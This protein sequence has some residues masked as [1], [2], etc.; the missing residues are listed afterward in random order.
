MASSPRRTAVKRLPDFRVEWQQLPTW[1]HPEVAYWYGEWRLIRDALEGE[2]QIK[3]QARLYLPKMDGMDADEYEAFVSRATFFNFT[4]RTASALNGSIMRR[5]P[6]LTGFPERLKARIERVT[7]EGQGLWE[8]GSFMADEVV[9]MGRFGILVDLPNVETTTPQPFFASYT[10]ENIL[11]WEIDEIDGELVLTKVVLRESSRVK[12]PNSPTSS[13]VP[14]QNAVA[15]G[16]YAY[17]PVYRVLEL[18]QT[19]EGRVYRQIVYKNK[20]TGGANTGGVELTDANIEQTIYP[21]RQGKALD[22]IPF[23]LVGAFQSTWTIEKSP[24]IDIARLNISHYRSY[25]QLE[26]GRFFTGFPIYYV[27]NSGIEGEDSEFRIGSSTVWMVPPGTKAGL[28]ELNGQGLKFLSDALDQ[29]EQQAASLGGRM[30]GVRTISTTESDNQLKLNERNEQSVL[31]K[32]TKSLDCAYTRALKLFAYLAG[33]TQAE[34]NDILVEFNK[35]FLFDGIGAREFRAIHSMYKD[36]VLPI[37]VVYHYLKKADVIPDWM[38]IEEF[39]SL[40]DKMGSFP[41][42]PD[43]E[44]RMEGY[45]DRKT[46]LDDENKDLDRT[47]EEKVAKIT[48]DAIKAKSQ[49]Q[50]GA[51]ENENRN[52]PS[53]NRSNNQ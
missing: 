40:L 18:L 41:N 45:P 2:R 23:V 3:D 12:T 26:H 38:S 44:A 17:E 50:P 47:S 10:A 7:R 46:Q 21:M 33:A 49:P 32:V 13:G 22:F 16:G 6:I 43:A 9:K 8:F 25:A 51:P 5:E 37:E 29:K 36:G 19:P 31:L 53:D 34:T 42:Q 35:D 1:V 52:Q 4:G 30:M 20:A 24:L 11:D 27:E 15:D 28:L 48:A 39:K 14:R